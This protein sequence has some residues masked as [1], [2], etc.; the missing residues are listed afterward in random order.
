MSDNSKIDIS[1][2]LDVLI[3]TMESSPKTIK[4]RRKKKREKWK[5]GYAEI[6]FEHFEKID[7]LITGGCSAF[8]LAEYLEGLGV[9]TNADYRTLER[10]YIREKRRRENPHTQLKKQKSKTSFA[11]SEL[12]Q[13]NQA[14]GKFKQIDTEREL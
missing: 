7:R 9:F 12:R 4:D 2:R 8:T 5:N 14:N 11:S 10:A 3:A 6:V 1:E 13:V